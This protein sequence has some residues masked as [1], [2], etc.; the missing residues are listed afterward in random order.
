MVDTKPKRRD[1]DELKAVVAEY[2]KSGLTITEYCRRTKEV[3]G[4]S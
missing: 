2:I 3:A 4:T 1:K